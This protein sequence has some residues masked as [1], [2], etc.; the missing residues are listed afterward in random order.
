M[1]TPIQPIETAPRLAA[2]PGPSPPRPSSPTALPAPGR[3]GRLQKQKLAFS[4]PLSPGGWECGGREGEGGVRAQRRSRD[5]DNRPDPDALLALAQ[6]EEERER[7]GKLKVFFGATAG[8]GKT[9][10]MLE[11]ARELQAR[12]VDVVV[13]WAETHGRKETAALLEGLERL[14]PCLVEHR[15]ITLQEFDLDAAK[16]RRPAV[17][18]VDELAHT[19]A[20]GLRH[21]KRWQDVEELLAAGI[22]VYT[23]VNVQHLESLNDLVGKITGVAV[24]ETVPDSVLERAEQVELVDLP[25]EELLKRLQE[26]KVYVPEQAARARES[27]FRPGN[28]IALRELALR[29]TAERVDAQMQRYRELH[30]VAETWPIA[31]RL[32]VAVSS[33]PNAA[34]LVRAA[35]RLAEQL[36]AEW[37]VVY[38]ETPAELRL[39]QQEK[40]RVWQT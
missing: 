2:P 17:I 21:A 4:N 18:L 16:A 27:F 38:V 36:R 39:P 31:E 8:V 5:M 12:G 30:G 6:A 40:D 34:Q 22:D 28:L 24:R 11:A 20:P 35:R 25:P 32:L 13:G 29:K 19:N 7:R 33:G 37:V 3:G 10:A 26:G 1:R 23:T 15:G 9:Y 14:P